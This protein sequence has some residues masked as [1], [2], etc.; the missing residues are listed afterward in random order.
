MTGTAL[1][2]AHDG[3]GGGRPPSGRGHRPILTDP[4]LTEALREVVM[5]MEVSRRTMGAFKHA[6]KKQ[7]HGDINM[8]RVKRIVMANDMFSLPYSGPSKMMI[9]SAEVEAAL[10]RM[11]K[12]TPED[13]LETIEQGARALI[14]F[15]GAGMKPLIEG[16]P[17]SAK[18]MSP[19]LAMRLLRQGADL[20]R[21][22][23]D[24]RSKL[25]GMGFERAD[26][27]SVAGVRQVTDERVFKT[28]GPKAVEKMITQER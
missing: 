24:M 20:A 3:R 22:V 17:D 14:I 18:G 27:G 25:H 26:D 21:A 4:A 19:D 23:M 2:R 16:L 28:Y 9:A 1:A 10:E 12:S 13:M 8:E 5:G 7:G 15:G 11:R 6:L